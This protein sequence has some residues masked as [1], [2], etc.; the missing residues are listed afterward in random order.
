MITCFKSA[1]V[2][3]AVG[4]LVG[5]PLFVGAGEIELTQEFAATAGGHSSGLQTSADGSV[6]AF[7]SEATDFTADSPAGRLHLYRKDV[8]TGETKRIS[9]SAS[10]RIESFSMSADG[11]M[12]AVALRRRLDPDAEGHAEANVY[13]WTEDGGARKISVSAIEGEVP[14]DD[15]WDPWVTP[16]GGFVFFK[17][18]ANNILPGHYF[19]DYG[20][21]AVRHNVESGHLDAGIPVFLEYSRSIL[22]SP[23]LYSPDGNFV[24]TRQNVPTEWEGESPFERQV[25]SPSINVFKI[26]EGR[27]IVPPL[28]ADSEE[29][30][31]EGNSTTRMRLDASGNWLSVVS[32]KPWP[33]QV[34]FKYQNLL[35]FNVDTDE[36]VVAPA[37]NGA[38]ERL[39]GPLATGDY[40]EWENDS[41]ARGLWHRERGFITVGD[42]ATGIHLKQSAAASPDDR[43]VVSVNLPG[44]E[45]IDRRRMILW[46]LETNDV[47]GF[48]P[49]MSDSD[50]RDFGNPNFVFS[51][52]SRYLFFETAHPGFV[53]ND[54]NRATDLFRYS[55]ETGEIL[56]ISARNPDLP[57]PNDGFTVSAPSVENAVTQIFY[58]HRIDPDADWIEAGTTETEDGRV[59]FKDVGSTIHRHKFY[60]SEVTPVEGGQ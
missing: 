19:R 10:G 5:G 15:C 44:N 6:V 12:I 9:L 27:V 36:I 56:L 48:G 42:G 32:W 35:S 31:F 54:N 30:E 26:D 51:G 8:S 2:A 3:L 28:P 53:E 33:N 50:A 22:F 16:D 1:V 37:K 23:I 29:V 20:Y 4:V 14:D 59:K 11:S 46:N 41:G 24:F 25:T 57:L 39:F 47:M 7:L 17:T 45:A 18:R 58:K 21:G 38:K 49:E 34:N 13:L 52:D 40:F 55:I 43:W 60:K